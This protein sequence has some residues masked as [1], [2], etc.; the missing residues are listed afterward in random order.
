MEVSKYCSSFKKGDRSNPDN[1]RP[2]YPLPVYV[3][4]CLSMLFTRIYSHIWRSTTYC[5]GE[6]QHGFQ[7]NRSCET[8]LIGTVNDIAENMNAGKQTDVILLDFSKAFDKIPHRIHLCHK[9]SHFGINGALLEW[10][11][12]FLNDRSQQV[13]VNE[14]KSSTSKVTSGVLQG[15]VLAPLL[16]LCFITKDL[17][18][19]IKL[20]ADDVLIYRCINSDDDCRILQRDLLY[21]WK[22]GTQVE[23][24]F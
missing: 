24:V 17:S 11:K 8:Q 18:S 13:I 7:Q 23:Y 22:L 3:V 6:E 19:S 2:V 15:T 5:A 1:Y 12:S 10:I 16:F 9:L 14:E 20:Y 4:S 21:P